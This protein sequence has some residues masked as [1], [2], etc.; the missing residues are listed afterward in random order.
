MAGYRVVGA[1]AL[2]KSGDGK[3]RYYYNG[4][5]IPED[6]VDKDDIQRLVALGLVEQVDS[7]GEPVASGK[8]A[9]ARPAQ[10]APKSEWEDYAVFR[11][12]SRAKAQSLSKRELI[13]A[14]PAE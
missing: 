13:D 5:S 3:V 10:V 2:V 7:P 8:A 6:I 1:V 9:L 11:G 14:F 12:M 4:A